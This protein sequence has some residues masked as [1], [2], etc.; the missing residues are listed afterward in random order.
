MAAMRYRHVTAPFPCRTVTEP[1]RIIKKARS[2][3]AN[4]ICVLWV[5]HADI[6]VIAAAAGGDSNATGVGTS[7][8]RNGEAA[9]ENRGSIGASGTGF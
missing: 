8:L 3:N 5:V 2:A 6:G 4:W 9:W 7:V 1:T